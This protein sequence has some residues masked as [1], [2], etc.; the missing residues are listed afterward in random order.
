[1][2][3]LTLKIKQY[4][5][6]FAAYMGAMIIPTAVSLA[7]NPLIALNMSPEDYAVSGYFLSFNSLISPLIGFYFIGY[8]TKEYFKICEEKRR[9]LYA[10]IFK[11]LIYISGLLSVFCFAALWIYMDVFKAEEGFPVMP[12]LALS[13]FVVPFGGIYAL[14]IARYRIERR[15]DMIF[16]YSIVST[17]LNVGLTLLFVVMMKMGAI[18]KLLAPFLGS[19]VFFLLVMLTSRNTFMVKVTVKRYL[20]L[21]TF[22][23]PLVIGAMLEYF[24]TGYTT[25]YLESLGNTT[26]YGIYVVGASIAGYIMTFALAVNNLFHPDIFEA[27]S[28]R[29]HRRLILFFTLELVCV[30]VVVGVMIIIAPFVVD[31]L[32]AGRY[33]SAVPYARIVSLAA[34]T[35]TLYYFLNDLSIV[36]NHKYHYLI[37]TVLGSIVIIVLMHIATNCGGYIGGAWMR[38]LSYLI[39]AVINLVLL[40]IS[41]RPN[42]TVCLT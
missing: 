31:I 35:S 22:C 17:I 29:N 27:A 24:T 42:K 6:N 11:S 37:T 16:L 26:E 3:E 7:I 9:V 38:G 2:S 14:R 20:S 12:Y 13:V 34:I 33:T 25:T 41:R 36:R 39:L 28:K 32:T 19:L 1:M 4:S 21:M 40:L 5:R 23:A 10:M 18:G 15:G 30:S 8:Y